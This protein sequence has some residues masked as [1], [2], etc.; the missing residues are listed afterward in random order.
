[1]V[2]FR[3]RTVTE[4]ERMFY[5]ELDYWQIPTPETYMNL[6]G[7]DQLIEAQVEYNTF[8]PEWTA[9]TLKIDEDN[10]RIVRKRLS[11]DEHGI[12]YCANPMNGHNQYI[13]FLVDVPLEYV[14]SYGRV[15]VGL[16][17]LQKHTKENLVSKRWDS[18]PSSLYW[19]VWSQKYT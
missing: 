11:S 4:E 19:Q 12:I 17:D 14:R 15:F 13:E 2:Y 7:D 6:G 1:M 3:G 10:A 9:Q 16:V 5:R 8:D 18:Q